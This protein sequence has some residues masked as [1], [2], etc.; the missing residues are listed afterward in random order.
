MGKVLDNALV[1]P[2][3][4]RTFESFSDVEAT[5]NAIGAI[6]MRM[7]IEKSFAPDIKQKRKPMWTA[8]YSTVA[9]W[10]G[11]LHHARCEAQPYNP[12]YNVM[13]GAKRNHQFTGMLTVVHEGW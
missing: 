8:A 9:N 3:V 10:Y 6:E 1:M 2:S 11:P 4:T 5:V 12:Q 13:E 7:A